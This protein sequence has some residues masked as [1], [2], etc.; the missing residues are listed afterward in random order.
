MEQNLEKNRNL[1]SLFEAVMLL[2]NAEECSHFFRDLCTVNELMALAERWEV[3]QWV[4]EGLPYRRISELTG[5]STTTITR[6][7]HWLKYGEGGYRLIL[8]RSK[9]AR[10][11][12]KP[13]AGE[14]D[15]A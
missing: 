9:A 12:A 15:E 6:I 1:W 7:A 4:D 3:A 10:R 11:Q 13:D 2:E 8:D 5:V 14:A